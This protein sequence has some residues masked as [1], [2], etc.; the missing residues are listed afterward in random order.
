MFSSIQCVPAFFLLY[1][2]SKFSWSSYNLSD[3]LL[4]SL[5]TSCIRLWIKP[6]FVSSSAARS[7]TST[8]PPRLCAKRWTN[9]LT[10]YASVV[11]LLP[12]CT[13]LGLEIRNTSANWIRHQHR[14]QNLIFT[15]SDNWLFKWKPLLT[16]GSSFKIHHLETTCYDNTFDWHL[17]N[18]V[19]S[20]KLIFDS[21]YK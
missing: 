18:D 8:Q 14:I 21:K 20:Y 5:A 6:L 11:N 2:G 16:T 15:P 7:H 3:I 4:T 10:N 13:N 12:G 9:Q 17:T 1:L 19:L